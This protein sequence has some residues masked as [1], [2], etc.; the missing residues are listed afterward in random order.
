LKAAVKS[1]PLLIVFPPGVPSE[2]AAKEIL[3]GT[4][5]SGQLKI[6]LTSLVAKA[7]PRSVRV[8][9]IDVPLPPPPKSPDPKKPEDVAKAVVCGLWC[10]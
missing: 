9:R 10:P 3:G 4:L 5:D 7:L 1:D 2:I 6:D 8:A